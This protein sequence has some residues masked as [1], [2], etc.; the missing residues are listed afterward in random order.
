MI[1][2]FLTSLNEKQRLAV[3]SINGPVFLVA[4][5]GTGKTRTLTTRIAYILHSG[6]QK[7]QVLALTFTNK[8]AKEMKTRVHNITGL[9]T[10][11]LWISTFHS[12]CLRILRQEILYLNNLYTPDFNVID[13]DDALKL[14]KEIIKEKDITLN[15][16]PKLILSKISNYRN[17]SIPNLT[18]SDK[19]NTVLLSICR[20]Y[21]LRLE[22]NNL[23]DFDGLQLLTLNLLENNQHLQIKYQN[24][25]KYILIDEWQDTSLIQYKIIKLL[26][27]KDQN[28]FVV[29]DPDQSIYSFRG[30]NYENADLFIKDYNPLILTINENYRSTPDILA[31]ANRLITNN[32]HHSLKKKLTTTKEKKH[33]VKLIN[34]KNS[35]DEAR[36][37]ASEIHRQKLAGIT[38][39]QIAILYRSNFL[40]KNIEDMLIK[41]RIPYLI[42]GGVSYYERLEVKDVLAYLKIAHNYKQNFYLKRILNVPK[43]GIGP[44]SIKQYENFAFIRNISLFESLKTL[45]IPS[46]KASISAIMLVEIIE[47]IKSFIDDETVLM[48]D[49]IDKILEVTHYDEYLKINFDNYDERIENIKELKSILSSGSISYAGSK[50]DILANIFDDMALAGSSDSN[51]NDAERVILST[52]HQV[53]GLEFDIVFL[54]ALEQGIFPSNQALIENN[55]DEERRICYVGVTRAAEQLYITSAKSRFYFGSHINMV[56]SDFIK[57]LKTPTNKQKLQKESNTY[58]LGDKINHEEYGSGVIVQ[59]NNDQITIAFNV[60]FGIKH[61]PIKSL[62]VKK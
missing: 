48:V 8:A 36:F 28:I 52:V 58:Q 24:Q 14:I 59:I 60:Q 10:F 61:F 55:I 29:G 27:N 53:K 26:S 25:F 16:A 41:Y 42:Y 11:D 50:S 15:L 62:L 23:I 31:A 6:I 39:N 17:R 37:I 3:T 45:K 44:A 9:N 30:A 1:L 33:P 51:I 7:D 19:N 12:F 54:T 32:S 46:K 20:D 38:P 47:K 21:L 5:A 2:D 40:S 18:L 49:L 4:G 56:E 22:Q 34:F 57:E 13:E 43:R 35:Y